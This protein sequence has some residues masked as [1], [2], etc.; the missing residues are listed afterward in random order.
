MN[1]LSRRSCWFLFSLAVTLIALPVQAENNVPGLASKPASHL[2]FSRGV[3]EIKTETL[4]LKRTSRAERKIQK[5]ALQEAVQSLPLLDEIIKLKWDLAPIQG[6]SNDTQ[7]ISLDQIFHDTVKHHSSIKQAEIAL[8]DAKAQAKEIH[9]PGLLNLI[10]P[11]DT[12][13]LKSAAQNNIQA[14]QW[15]LSVARQ[16]ALLDAARVYTELTQALLAKYQAFQLI[17]QGR[18]QLQVEQARFTAG[19]SNS[20]DVTQIE[21]SLL[22][23]YTKYLEADN[24]FYSAALRLAVQV[25]LP[26]NQNFLPEQSDL[27]DKGQ[28]TSPFSLIPADIAPDRIQKVIKKRPDIQVLRYRRDAL[29]QLV[30]ASAGTEKQK[31]IAELHQLEQEQEKAL[32]STEAIAAKAYSD[33]LLAQKNLLLVHQ[34]FNLSNQMVYQLQ[35]S[36]DAGFSSETEMLMGRIALAQSRA[37]LIGALS[38]YNLSQIQLLYEMGLLDENSLSKPVAVPPNIL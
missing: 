38:A 16:K 24:L 2:I 32:A 3:Q 25:S 30:K 11:V 10:Y 23:R 37:R 14:A 18:S 19:E 20:F 5:K 9:D 13:A 28:A 7:K 31:K 6:C 27:L 22:D 21:I 4:T 33:Y 35:V 26:L 17:E 15:Q 34:G 12:K 36:Y 8:E 1:N 29:A